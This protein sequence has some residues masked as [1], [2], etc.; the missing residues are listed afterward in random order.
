MCGVLVLAV[1]CARLPLYGCAWQWC[2]Y[3]GMCATTRGFQICVSACFWVS[4]VLCGMRV[5]LCLVG[6]S[7]CGVFALTIAASSSRDV[8]LMHER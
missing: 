2:Q 4:C 3:L 1:F 6:A 8:G 5:L 7:L